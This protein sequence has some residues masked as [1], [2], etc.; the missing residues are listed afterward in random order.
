MPSPL[1]RSGANSNLCFEPLS[2]EPQTSDPTP[3]VGLATVQRPPVSTSARDY[4]HGA[5]VSQGPAPAVSGLMSKYSRGYSPSD[6]DKEQSQ[7]STAE[8]PAPT[9]KADSPECDGVAAFQVTVRRFAP[10]E[11]FGLMYGGDAKSRQ[12]AG[13]GGFTTDEEAT[14]RVTTRVEV[15]D[16]H[17][18]ASSS[19]DVSHN[20][21]TNNTAEGKPATQVESDTT[22]GAGHLFASSAGANPL[23]PA[24]ATP[25][26]DSRLH[27]DYCATDDALHVAGELSG[28]DFPNAEVYVTDR[29]GNSVLLSSFATDGGQHTGPLLHLWGKGD[30][31]LGSFDE[32]IAVGKDGTFRMTCE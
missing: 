14:A 4:F 28:D 10:F 22:A 31:S 1:E 3:E 27:L 32:T 18:A 24:F 8:P 6:F 25:S 9:E 19:S 12:S 16:S 7:C 20:V 17:V 30:A 29:V 13:S 15:Q 26:I 2:S 23:T 21:L 5:A 11:T